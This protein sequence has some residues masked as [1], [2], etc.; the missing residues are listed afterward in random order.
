MNVF[1]RRMTLTD[2]MQA[3]AYIS[4]LDPETLEAARR[5]LADI[6][7]RGE[8]A[9]LEYAQRFGDLGKGHK[10]LY[11]PDD[12]AA[13]L[14]RLPKTQQLLLQRTADRI[15]AFAL[16]QRACL[17]DL[18]TAIRGGR[19][20]HTC[21]PVDSV[22]CYA[23]GGRYPLPSSVLMTAV[24]ARAAGVGR[25]WVASP[26]PTDVTLAAAHLA[27][28]DGLL[29]LGGVQGVAALWRGLL[30]VTP[31]DMIVG[32]GNRWVTAAKYLVSAS[33]GI[34]MLA[35]PSE[36]LVLADDSADPA[37]IAADLLAQAE[38]DDDAVPMLV[39]PCA[40]LVAEVEEQLVWQLETLPTGP[41]ARAALRNSFAVVTSNLAESI[42]A[43]DRIAPEHLE[44]MTREPEAV[45]ARVRHAGAVFIGPRSAEVFGDYGLGP[46]HVLP[47]GATA[48][49]RA[50]LS[51]LTFLRVRTWLRM[52]AEL[53]PGADAAANDVADLAR[54]ERLEAH[55]RASERRASTR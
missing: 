44:I 9:A 7:Q 15:R 18:D 3:R 35:G 45:A 28:A 48:R 40:A 5:M 47:T 20:G 33:V 11:G 53:A 41:T 43:A 32:P 24:T 27:G 49:A 39:T 8:A 21:I 4:P 10:G 12:L 54:L 25:V 52:D 36:L 23:P 17:T 14:A 37:L 30:G 51:V 26:R 6:D 55:A 31:C 42:A 46:N 1:L 38:H 34:D 2:L 19:A 29:A 22:G 16:A 13:A 50:G